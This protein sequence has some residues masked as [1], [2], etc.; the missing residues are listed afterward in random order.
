M[1]EETVS[2]CSHQFRIHSITSYYD[3]HF[4][5][6][7]GAQDVDFVEMVII[8]SA[9]LPPLSLFLRDR[10]I[11]SVCVP[12]SNCLLSASAIVTKALCERLS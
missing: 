7:T 11:T 9:Y 2:V 5:I 4:G 6:L 3:S 12:L 1:E 8:L 10:Q